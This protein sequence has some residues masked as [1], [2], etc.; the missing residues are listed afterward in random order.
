[1]SAIQI[2]IVS[3]E[4]STVPTAKGSYGVAEV[5]YKNLTFENKIEAKKVMSF[6]HK[7]V[8]NTLKSAEM[9]AVFTVQ[10]VKN[11]KGFWDWV[12]LG[13]DAP[14]ATTGGTTVATAAKATQ[15][16]KSTYE[17]PEER[18]KKQ[19]YIV[20]QSSITAAIAILKTDKKNPTPEEVMQVAD[21]FVHYVM[22][23]SPNPVA[24]VAQET[25]DLTDD[26]PY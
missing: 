26:V 2:K 14:A 13:D 11:D 22:T 19:V 4:N 21:M 24:T 10:R 18:A 25:P 16:P 8:Y 23:D 1:M 5:T 12:S 3:V 15:A 9:G 7:D 20:R 6:T 17:T